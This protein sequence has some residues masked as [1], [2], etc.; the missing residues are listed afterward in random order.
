MNK[1]L[2]RKKKP[3][4]P[5]QKAEELLLLCM[6]DE[7]EPLKTVRIIQREKKKAEIL[8]KPRLVYLCTSNYA[9]KCLVLFMKIVSH[10]RYMDSLEV[11]CLA[12]DRETCLNP[13]SI[14]SFLGD[15][16]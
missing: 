7:T 12:V 10:Q 13:C 11:N 16:E 6:H 15:A 8:T 5:P 3:N 2:R 4:T 9:E 1:T 14:D